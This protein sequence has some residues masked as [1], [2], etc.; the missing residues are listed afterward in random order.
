[1]IGGIFYNWLNNV[2]AKER[3]DDEK[4]EKEESV[5][6]VKSVSVERDVEIIII[7]SLEKL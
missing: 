5:K 2:A 4:Y 6:E 7:E 3:E 1:M